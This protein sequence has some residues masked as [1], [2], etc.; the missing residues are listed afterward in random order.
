MHQYELEI[1][2]KI[3]TYDLVCDHCG[4]D[5]LNTEYWDPDREGF[6]TCTE[7][8]REEWDYIDLSKY[9]PVFDPKIHTIEGGLVVKAE[10]PI[11]K[12]TIK[13]A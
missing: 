6:P 10:L 11:P 9:E 1:F 4:E 3:V 2:D 13:A 8:M 12:R 5:E 7:C